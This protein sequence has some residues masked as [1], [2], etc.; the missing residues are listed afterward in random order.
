MGMLSATENSD[1]NL[2]DKYY[3]PVWIIVYVL[4]RSNKVNNYWWN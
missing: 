4:E 3:R 2:K 1:A